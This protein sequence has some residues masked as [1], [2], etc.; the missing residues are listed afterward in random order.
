MIA[1]SFEVSSRVVSAVEPAMMSDQVAGVNGHTYDST[2]GGFCA[3]SDAELLG[4][5]CDTEAD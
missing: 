2:N 1:E 5:E 4:F 3:S